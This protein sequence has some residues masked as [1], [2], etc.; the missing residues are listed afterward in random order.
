MDFAQMLQTMQGGT[1]AI[2]GNELS[3]LQKALTAGYGTDPA[4]FTGGAAF[5]IQSLDHTMKATIQENQHFVL[6]NALAKAGAGATVDEWSEQQSIGGFLGGSTNTETGD[7]PEGQGDYARRTALVKFLMTKAEVSLVSTLGNNIVQ[8][9]AVEARAAALRL[10]TDAEYLCFEGNASVVPTEFDGMDVQIESLGSSDH[11]I[12]LEG[13]SLASGN[14]VTRAVQSVVGFGNFGKPTDLFLSNGTQADLDNAMDP[15]ARV[16]LVGLDGKG[17]IEKGSPVAGIRTSWGVMKNNPAVFI[18]EENMMTPFQLRH[19][20]VAA[21]QAA[22]QP[23]AVAAVASAGSAASKWGAAHAGQFYY[24]VTGV[25]AKGQ[26]TGVMTAAVTVAAGD[27]VT[28]TI[29]R[30]LGGAETGYVIYRSRKNGTNALTDV[31]E[32]K[33]IPSA[34]ATTVFVDENRDLPGACRARLLSMAPGSDAINW[35]QLLPMTEFQLYP[36]KA[37]TLPWAQLLFGYLRLAKR[38]HHVVLKNIVNA[39]QLWKPFA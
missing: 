38:K 7:I 36:T 20:A 35:R 32:M 1:G 15:A 5:R 17:A 28:L 21:A 33:R 26:S 14:H 24:F 8:S 27:K 16:N 13:T 18:R 19:G 39:N 34:G 10:L 22:L 37:A 3:L 6:F 31:R 23:A 30:S 25:N 12:D 11:V 2:G 4:G 29:T 9:K